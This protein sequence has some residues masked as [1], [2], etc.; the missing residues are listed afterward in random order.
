MPN[1]ILKESVCASDTIDRLDWFQEVVFYRLI[2]SADDYGRL[3]AR[4][5][6]LKSRLFPLKETLAAT[7]VAQAVQRL[8]EVGLV[9]CY[10]VEGQPYLLLRGWEAHQKIRT[11]RL[12]YPPPEDDGN[13][14]QTSVHDGNNAH[15]PVDDGNT[16]LQS[17]A[18]IQSE[19]VSESQSGSVSEAGAV[20]DG[21]PHREKYGEYGWI[22]LTGEEYQGLVQEMGAPELT[23]LIRY[24]DDIVQQTGNKYRWKDWRAVLRRAHRENW[25]PRGEERPSP[26]KTA[27]YD[28]DE[29]EQLL[30]G[31]GRDL[32]P[33]L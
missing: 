28:L 1:R 5:Q 25:G 9:R 17:A 6:L 7:Q 23:R 22:R 26:Q 8:E 20:G 11:K 4:P 13:P 15:T 12:R 14:A 32:R 16:A 27:S 19:S 33:L 30:S 29:I 24:V 3:D 2:V 21:L 10:Q 18:L 31:Q